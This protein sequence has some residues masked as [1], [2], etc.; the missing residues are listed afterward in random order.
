MSADR[1]EPTAAVASVLARL[2]A[3]DRSRLLAV[4]ARR[5]HDL[6][7]AEDVLADAMVRAM[8][9]WPRT[10]IPDRPAAW[11]LTVAKNRA[12]D[13][14]RGDAA[15]ARRL[16]ALR[17][18]D[19]IGTGAA[20]DHSEDIV[21]SLGAAD[22][23]D[24]RLTLFFTCS[25]PTLRTGEHVALILR[26]LGGLSTA[27][28]AAGFLVDTTTMQQ[29]LVRAKR[30]IRVTGIP[31]RRPTDKEVADRLPAVLRALYL[32]FTQGYVATTGMAHVRPE[33]T[34]EAIRLTRVLARLLPESTEV[35]GLLALFLLTE[36][37]QPAR[38]DSA[39]L[40]V[41]LSRQERS[42]W[43]SALIVE[44]L[45]LV[46]RA[47]GEPEAASYTIQAAI[48]AL[49]AEAASFADTDWRQ[50]RVLYAMLTRLEPTPMVRL[51]EAVAIFRCDGPRAGLRALDALPLEGHRPF[52]I[53]RG[54]MLREHGDE[55]GAA[56]EAARA[57]KCPGN[58]AES[59]FID[60]DG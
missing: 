47:A 43:V 16:A 9:T 39:G 28:V 60:L 57:R 44:G 54:I 40:P 27:E 14:V 50:I 2:G 58:D 53:A 21:D 37:R 6:D 29:R 32:I 59:A 13:I 4:L 30:R 42:R 10:G 5:F 19:E 52:H 33:L 25:H 31:F 35:R 49:H 20:R 41:P 15:R 38:S 26:C 17:I 11:L 8:E 3:E 12:L 24:E 46:T 36:A 55:A 48:A 34:A 51:A 18:E 23:P 45:S 7:L 1:D 22:I 56:A